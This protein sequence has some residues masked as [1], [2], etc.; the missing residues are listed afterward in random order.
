MFQVALNET[1]IDGFRCILRSDDKVC[2][3]IEATE[4]CSE[5]PKTLCDGLFSVRSISDGF[6]CYCLKQSIIVPDFVTKIFPTRVLRWESLSRIEIPRSIKLIADKCFS[7]FQSLSE[8]IFA[9]DSQLRE[10]GG[11]CECTSLCRIDI[12]SSVEK[13]THNAFYKC[14]SLQEVLFRSDNHLRELGGFCE[15]TSL[16]R[17][18]IPSSVKIIT[19]NAFIGCKSLQEIIFRSDNHLS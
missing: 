19:D 15:C 18:K 10:L 14:T 9:S 12:P 5:I 16:C 8:V 17:I 4:D 6:I 13:I 11:F 2:E 3:I 1:V 7:N